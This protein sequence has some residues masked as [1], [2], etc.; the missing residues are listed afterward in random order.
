MQLE[1]NL[2]ALENLKDN[3]QFWIEKKKKK[4]SVCYYLFAIVICYGW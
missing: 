2:T 4:K 1:S 3:E